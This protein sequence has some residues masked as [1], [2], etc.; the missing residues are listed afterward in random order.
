MNALNIIKTL[1]A[2]AVGLLAGCSG[3]SDTQMPQAKRISEVDVP[4]YE[5]SRSKPIQATIEQKPGTNPEEVHPG[6]K[7]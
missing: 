4:Q 2:L 7:E 3:G 6:V 1:L 5:G